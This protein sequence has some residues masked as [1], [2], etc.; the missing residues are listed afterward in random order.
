[1]C[2][3]FAYVGEEPCLLEDVL[4]TPRHALT[5][6]VLDHYLPKLIPQQGTADEVSRKEAESKLR[7]AHFNIDGVGVAWYT[8]ARQEFELDCDGLRPCVYKTIQPP[9]NDRIQALSI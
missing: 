4:I 7:N 2:R 1:M 8:D 9:M 3:W 5:K 6:Q